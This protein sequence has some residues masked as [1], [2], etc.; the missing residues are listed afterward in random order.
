MADTKAVRNAAKV[1]EQIKKDL[2]LALYYVEASLD[3][4]TAQDIGFAIVGAM[5]DLI[6]KGISPIEGAGRFPAYKWADVRNQLKKEKSAISKALRKNQKQL[7]NFR[8]KNK[9]QILLAQKEAN[10]KQLAGVTGRY[11]F[12]AEAIRLGK[13]PRPV[14]LFLTGEFLFHLE[15]IVTGAAGKHGLEIGFFDSEQAKK[16]QGHAEGVNGQPQRPIIPV[17]RQDFAQ[18]IQ[19]AIYKKMEEAIDRAAARQASSR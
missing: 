19:R 1:A 18:T 5:I 3:E 13:K 17:G 9:R 7:V 4:S 12:T 10:R 16:E 11:P 6:S 2:N 15:A 8:R 14:N